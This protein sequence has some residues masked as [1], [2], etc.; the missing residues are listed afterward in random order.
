MSKSKIDADRETAIAQV[1]AE[2][3]AL[4]EE[5]VAKG[6]AYRIVK[7]D[8]TVCYGYTAAGSAPIRP[9]PRGGER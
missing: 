4:L 2:L 7:P 9:H 5:W 8:G 3:T 6:W 1:A